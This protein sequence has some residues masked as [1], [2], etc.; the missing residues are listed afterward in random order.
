VASRAAL[1]LLPI[2]GVR[3]DAVVLERRGGDVAAAARRIE[4]GRA[5]TLGYVD[6]WRWRMSG[7]GEAPEA[8][9]AWLAGLVAGVAY[10]PRRELAAAGL[11]PAPLANLTSL[12]GA[13]TPVAVEQGAAAMDRSIW[14]VFGLLCGALLLEWA[15]RRL[16]GVA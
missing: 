14:W 2:A 7:R 9:R 11:N 6:T 5:V 12:L 1:D 8:H 10:S 4:A 13:A 15:S 16:R 3:D